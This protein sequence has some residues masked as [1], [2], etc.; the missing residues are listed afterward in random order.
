MKID[1]IVKPSMGIGKKK[2]LSFGRVE[3]QVTTDNVRSRK[4][5]GGRR[6][7]RGRGVVLTIWHVVVR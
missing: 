1:F 6:R 2:E 3:D 4:K 5:E 7:G